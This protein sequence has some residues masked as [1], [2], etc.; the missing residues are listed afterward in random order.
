MNREQ[1][2]DP[3][4]KEP[5]SVHSAVLLMQGKMA[6]IQTAVALLLA[7]NAAWAWDHVS[8]G[9]L[10]RLVEVGEPVLVACEF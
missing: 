6:W 5:G 1:S 7:M 8:S 3:L 2:A 4:D 10:R 9:E